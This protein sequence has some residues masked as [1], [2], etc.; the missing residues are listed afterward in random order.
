MCLLVGLF[1]TQ[2]RCCAGS[3]AG[4]ASCAP[5]ELH[6]SRGLLYGFHTKP[7]REDGTG[8]RSAQRGEAGLPRS[9]AFRALRSQ[10]HRRFRNAHRCAVWIWSRSRTAALRGGKADSGPRD[11]PAPARRSPNERIRLQN[12]P[13]SANRPQRGS[14]CGVA[15]YGPRVSPS[16]TRSSAQRSVTPPQYPRADGRTDQRGPNGPRAAPRRPRRSVRRGGPTRS[17]RG[18][19]GT[20]NTRGAERRPSRLPPTR[21]RKRRAER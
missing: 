19:R 8:L 20:P 10:C 18:P 13:L 2:P 14:S 7:R 6:R 4:H 5:V 21:G 3:T 9:A 15:P 12:P 17:R 11:S 1:T 16:R